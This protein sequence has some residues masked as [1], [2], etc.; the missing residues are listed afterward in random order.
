MLGKLSTYKALHG[1]HW[2][3]TSHVLERRLPALQSMLSQ[4]R[5][6]SEPRFADV[7]DELGLI[8]AELGQG[9]D[10]P[11]GPNT[12]LWSAVGTSLEDN[13]A[14]NC[15]ITALGEQANQVSAK[16]QQARRGLIRH[17]KTLLG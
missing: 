17:P 13:C 10:A 1:M 3:S 7:E 15:I 16:A 9:G 5:D 14:L 12:S 2:L 8:G 11:G 6:T 4:T